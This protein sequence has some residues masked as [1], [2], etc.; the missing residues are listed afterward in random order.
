M[1]DFIGGWNRAPGASFINILIMLFLLSPVVTIAWL[2]A[3]PV[4]YFRQG[5]SQKGLQ[6][7]LMTVLALLLFIESLAIDYFILTQIRM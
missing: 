3:E 2:I 5:K 7:L 4:R 1:Y 6:C